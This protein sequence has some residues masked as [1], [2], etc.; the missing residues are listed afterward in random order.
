M[1]SIIVLLEHESDKGVKVEQKNARGSVP[2]I[3]AGGEA[4]AGKSLCV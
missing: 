4:E 2:L 1:K 3:L